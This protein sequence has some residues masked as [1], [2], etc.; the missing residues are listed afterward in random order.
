M[1]TGQSL[2]DKAAAPMQRE[3]IAEEVNRWDLLREAIY[4]RDK[5][6][7]DKKSRC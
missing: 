4:E 2:L 3:G 6:E 7:P 5:S 1:W